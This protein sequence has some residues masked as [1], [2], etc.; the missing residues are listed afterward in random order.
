LINTVT[1]HPFC[2]QVKYALKFYGDVVTKKKFEILPGSATVVLETVFNITTTLRNVF[3]A[4][5]HSS[6][7]LSAT[8]MV[9]QALSHLIRWSD[10]IL[11]L[12]TTKDASFEQISE[13][14]VQMEVRSIVDNLEI[15]INDL[16]QV[17][18]HKAANKIPPPTTAIAC[19]SPTTTVASPIGLLTE[20]D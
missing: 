8:N 3:P 12:S 10:D 13:S 18:I 2:L 17:V 1:D 16:V 6:S 9:H 11:L 20:K 15:A 7:L 19:S 4:G 5:E 14:N